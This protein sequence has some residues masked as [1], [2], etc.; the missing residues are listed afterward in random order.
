[1]V[2]AA[3]RRGVRVIEGSTEDRVKGIEAGADDFLTKPV[4]EQELIARIKTA[5]RFKHAVDDEIGELRKVSDHLAKF[6][7]D[8]VT[9]LIAANPSDPELEKREADVSILF[10]D[11]TGYGRLSETIAPE[12][13]NLLVERYFSA[14]LDRIQDSGGEVSGSAGDGLMAIFQDGDPNKHAVT[15]ADTALALFA[16]NERLNAENSIQPLGIHIGINSGPALVG[17]TRYHGQRG[18]RW[19]FTADG[20]V[21]NLAARLADLASDGEIIAGPE[22]VQRLGERYSL[23]RRGRENLKNMAEPV[24]IIRILGPASARQEPQRVSAQERDLRSDV[25]RRL[26]TILATDLFGDMAA[27]QDGGAPTDAPPTPF[28]QSIDGLLDEHRGRVLETVDDS[29]IAEFGSPLAAVRCAVAI[30]QALPTRGQD[31]VTDRRP[32]AGIGIG[33]GRIVVKE[34]RAAGDGVDVAAR[35][36]ELARPGDVCVA[37]VVYENVR[38][39]IDDA[40]EDGGEQEVAGLARP[41]RM[42]RLQVPDGAASSGD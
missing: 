4:N 39:E 29:F 38:R 8:A 33:L 15:A 19:V 34:G 37:D 3:A 9:R 28:Q 1:M 30:Q 18:V 25:S 14:F 11:I 42:Y 10:L 41:V 2:R 40:F 21:I 17:P 36:K 7:P 5:L 6:V 22:T 31:T 27:R 24:E 35:L 26:G 20:R 32:S 16:A 12:V 23:E 13:L